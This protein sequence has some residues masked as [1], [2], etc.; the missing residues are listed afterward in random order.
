MS[1]HVM[2]LAELYKLGRDADGF[3][4]EYQTLFREKG[5]VPRKQV[6]KINDQYKNCGKFYKVFE[7]ETKDIYAKGAKK[8]AEIRAAEDDAGE[9][10]RVLSDSLK[11]AKKP[12]KAKKVDSTPNIN[13]ELEDARKE[14][15]DLTGEEVHHLKQLKGI[16]KMID[17]YNSN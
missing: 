3:T 11:A 7:D 4:K 16:R 12:K 10:G 14:Y 2:V 6:D 15:F 17:E 13:E 9:L 5:L 1:E 8:V